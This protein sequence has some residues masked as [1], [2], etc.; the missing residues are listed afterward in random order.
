LKLIFD[1]TAFGYYA[2]GRIT[3]GLPAQEKK[4]MQGNRKLNF[5]P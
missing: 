4:I 3:F 2:K 5:F 1:T